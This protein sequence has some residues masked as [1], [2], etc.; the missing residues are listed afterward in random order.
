MD[1]HNR[2]LTGAIVLY[3]MRVNGSV[4]KNDMRFQPN[5]EMNYGTHQGSNALAFCKCGEV[6][7]LFYADID[8][9]SRSC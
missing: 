3:A 6:F 7:F 9:H 8:P 2:A 5:T 1:R 4:Q